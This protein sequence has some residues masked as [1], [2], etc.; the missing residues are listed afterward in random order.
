[1]TIINDSRVACIGEE[2]SRGFKKP[3]ENSW[4]HSKNINPIDP[5]TT[6]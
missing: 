2:L 3:L 4:I 1:M 6:G 5:S